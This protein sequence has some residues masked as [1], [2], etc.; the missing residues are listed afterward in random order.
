MRM[1]RMNR[2]IWA[3]RQAGLAMTASKER[4]LKP[5]GLASAHYSVLS[6]VSEQPGV[7]GAE[8]ARDLGVTPQ[9]V[10]GLVKRLTDRG[11]IER[12]AHSRHKQVLEMWLTPAGEAVLVKADAE[13]AALEK[14]IADILGD[15]RAEQL[16]LLL[17][18][19]AEG[20]GDIPN[21]EAG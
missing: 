2:I 14:T 17:E 10:V 19:L 13:L 21:S 6:A 8:L 4:R 3:A 20:M 12:R 7:T 15:D 5:L 16:R 18:E 9:N 1:R 11:L